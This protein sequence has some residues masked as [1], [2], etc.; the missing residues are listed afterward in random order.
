MKAL[1]NLAAGLAMAGAAWGMGATAAS[2]SDHHNWGG[3]YI[4]ASAGWIGTDVGWTYHD[5]AGAIVDRPISS[6]DSDAALVGGHVGIQHQFG[7]IVAGVEAGLSGPLG[8]SDDWGRTSCF[9]PAFWC[10]SRMRGPMVTLGARL[11]WAVNNHWMIYATGGAV[12]AGIETREVNVATGL[13][14]QFGT[15]GRHWGWY[16]GG[17]LEYALTDSMILGVEYQR[18]ELDDDVHRSSI[19]AEHRRIDAEA[20]VIKARLSFKL[21]R[22]DHYEDSLK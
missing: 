2:A 11:G 18:I 16:F 17:G 15:R 1:R 10:D 12:S 8:G 19:A 6:A 7:Q 5:P 3:I 9:N 4:G 20:D 21:G 14:N 22:R 13:P